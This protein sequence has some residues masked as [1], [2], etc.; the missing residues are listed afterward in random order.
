MQSVQLTGYPT[1][2]GGPPEHHGLRII[3]PGGKQEAVPESMVPINTRPLDFAT[4]GDALF[5]VVQGEPRG[6]EARMSRNNQPPDPH[7]T[8]ASTAAQA[9]LWLASDRD[10]FVYGSAADE[11]RRPLFVHWDGEH[12]APDAPPPG[13]D[14]LVAFDR[15]DA[16]AERVFG[17]T[18]DALSLWER[19]RG[20]AWTRIDLPH[21]HVAEK[22]DN[23]WLMN[24]E[25]W[26][27]VTSDYRPGRL[28][29]MAP[30]QQVY[31]VGKGLEPPDPEDACFPPEPVA[32]VD[33]G[34]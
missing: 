31:R 21:P 19:P 28:L 9:H 4:F 12:W 2:S 34:A 27:H 32:V 14:R 10:V 24:G 6:S 3:R 22:I 16:G 11:G 20:G 5:V 18:G 8:F 29:R 17:F 23:Q 7:A 25:A 33:G 13:V 26:L 30:V 15:T 1:A